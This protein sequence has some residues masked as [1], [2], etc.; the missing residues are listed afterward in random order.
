MSKIQKGTE[1]F[2]MFQDFWKMYND[3]HDVELGDEFCEKV[4]NALDEFANKYK[5]F[6]MSEKLWMA[7]FDYVN[8]EI[9]V[10]EG[11]R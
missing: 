7:L 2:Q 11:K 6:Y 3:F 8:H 9:L 5:Q 1:E 4:K 10:K